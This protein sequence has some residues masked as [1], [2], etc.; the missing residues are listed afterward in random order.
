MLLY[1]LCIGFVEKLRLFE[2][3]LL[4]MRQS[5]VDLLRMLSDRLVLDAVFFVKNCFFCRVWQF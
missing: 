1:G 3:Q 2:S 5:L 4:I